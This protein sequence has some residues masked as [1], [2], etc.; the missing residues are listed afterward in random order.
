MVI[1]FDDRG[2]SKKSKFCSVCFR[3]FV[4]P[5]AYLAQ[6]LLFYC[7]FY[8]RSDAG[9]TEFPTG[10]AVKSVDHYEGD[11]GVEQEA[12]PSMANK[13]G[14]MKD[15]PSNSVFANEF[16]VCTLV[17]QRRVSAPNVQSLP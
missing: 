7:M 10:I 17:F 12:G 8:C 9:T 5:P 15:F 3:R 13:L 1:L 2:H 6:I 14:P 16:F 11:E 4:C